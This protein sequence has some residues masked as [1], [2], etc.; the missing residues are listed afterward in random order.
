MKVYSG[1]SGDLVHEGTPQL[2]ENSAV[3]VE[4][5][6]S[7]DLQANAEYYAIISYYITNVTSLSTNIS[8]S[9]C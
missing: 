6:I 9:E 1:G 8:I 3:V 4:A 7:L 5:E 2:I